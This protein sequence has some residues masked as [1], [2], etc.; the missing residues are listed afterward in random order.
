MIGFTH[1]LSIYKNSMSNDDFVI[2][3][4]TFHHF[5]HRDNI[6]NYN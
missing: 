2:S 4:T 6:H 3:T 5:H 1:A